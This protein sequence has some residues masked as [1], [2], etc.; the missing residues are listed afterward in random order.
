MKLCAHVV[1]LTLLFVDLINVNNASNVRSEIVVIYY[2][3]LIIDDSK[4][5]SDHFQ[6]Q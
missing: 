5:I 4:S 1:N 2:I 6:S 3:N